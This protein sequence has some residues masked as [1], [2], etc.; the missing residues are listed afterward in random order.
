MAIREESRSRLRE[1]WAMG[2]NGGKEC[3]G[4]ALEEEEEEEK[5][6]SLVVIAR[7][8]RRRGEGLLEEQRRRRSMGS[9]C[10]YGGEGIGIGEL[11]AREALAGIN[12]S[13]GTAIAA[14]ADTYTT[15]GLPFTR[16]GEA[17]RS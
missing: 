8:R 7:G 10:C 1:E 12:T 11:P 14:I 13:H 5:E 17:R 16:P 3:E 4:E 6:R 9:L 2:S 15:L